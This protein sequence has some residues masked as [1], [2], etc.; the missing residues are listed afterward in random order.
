MEYLLLS[1]FREGEHT[2][3]LHVQ[4]ESKKKKSKVIMYYSDG[5]QGSLASSYLRHIFLSS[6]LFKKEV[7]WHVSH[8]YYPRL[9][10]YV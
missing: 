7:G 9:S 3:V 8:L 1:G 6:G 10:Y 4:R 5:K 2:C